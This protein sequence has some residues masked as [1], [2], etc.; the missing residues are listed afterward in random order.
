M[1]VT[2]RKPLH[3]Y[4]MQ[5]NN[6]Q[7]MINNGQHL[8]I[9]HPKYSQI[10]YQTEEGLQSDVHNIFQ[11]ATKSWKIRTKWRENKQMN[12]EEIIMA[13]PV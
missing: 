11:Q 6:T 3:V 12:Q 7:K 10:K 5:R 2:P 1:E 8:V 9:K 13:T 4:P